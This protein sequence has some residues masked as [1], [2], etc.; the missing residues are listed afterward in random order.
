MQVSFGF[1]LKVSISLSS[2]DDDQEASGTASE[3]VL[4]SSQP[5]SERLTHTDAFQEKLAK[6]P[7]SQPA[8]HLPE[9]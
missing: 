6:F 5:Q 2:S 4:I 9:S 8:Q 7:I 3:I 1:T